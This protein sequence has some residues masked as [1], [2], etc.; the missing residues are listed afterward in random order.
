MIPA[1]AHARHHLV[2]V[3][4]PEREVMAAHLEQL[5]GFTLDLVG[6]LLVEHHE[7]RVRPVDP[8]QVHGSALCRRLARPLRE[9]LDLVGGHTQTEDVAVEAERAFHVAYPDCDM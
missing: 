3:V 9:L 2:D 6:D 4:D 8:A 5:G 1:G 7:A